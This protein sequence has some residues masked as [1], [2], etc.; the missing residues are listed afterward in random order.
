MME[1]LD[2]AAPKGLAYW[3]YQLMRPQFW[4]SV[5]AGLLGAAAIQAL[6]RGQGAWRDESHRAEPER[7]NQIPRGAWLL[8][9]KENKH[10]EKH[11]ALSMRLR[12]FVEI[13]ACV[14]LPF[15]YFM[16]IVRPMLVFALYS[17]VIVLPALRIHGLGKLFRKPVLMVATVSPPSAL[18]RCAAMF[19]VARCLGF[20]DPESVPLLAQNPRRTAVLDKRI[21]NGTM[22]S[23]ICWGQ[24]AQTA[25]F[26]LYASW[27][28]LQCCHEFDQ[29]SAMLKSGQHVYKRRAEQFL[30]VKEEG[31]STGGQGE[32]S[33]PLIDTEQSGSVLLGA[34]GLEA[35]RD[36][37][38][39]D[40]LLA[41]TVVDSLLDCSSIFLLL[42][43][44]NYIFSALLLAVVATSGA[45]VVQTIG[46]RGILDER[47][48]SIRL[49]YLTDRLHDLIDAERG[50]EAFFSLALTSYGFIFSISTP[51]Q[52]FVQGLSM[53]FSAW[54][55]SLWVY[56]HVD[57]NLEFGYETMNSE[58]IETSQTRQTSRALVASGQ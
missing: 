18:L 14:I 37:S 58:K 10:H 44:Q 24:T 52:V 34:G 26:A 50:F 23:I 30:E 17:V 20:P 11:H 28:A 12:R 15:G 1:L 19:L 41:F 4:V 40:S 36:R 5:L 51:S 43:S 48:K 35:F 39:V 25:V 21:W 49:G 53:M 6:Q 29:A 47:A 2:A 7:A 42:T 32:G 13:I 45:H 33:S 31:A 38:S 55:L 27:S 22:W 3:Q 57:L 46:L 56:D 54:S 8:A 16:T 9:A